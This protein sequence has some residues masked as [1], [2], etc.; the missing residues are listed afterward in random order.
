MVERTEIVTKE[1]RGKRKAHQCLDKKI[2]AFVG[3]F[4]SSGDKKVK[5]LVQI[6]VVVA[7]KMTP[8]EIVDLFFRHRVEILL[9]NAVLAKRAER[10]HNFSDCVEIL[11]MSIVST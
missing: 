6:K 10:I 11:Y 2:R 7:V 1:I 9:F 8:N 5:R 3:K 4:V